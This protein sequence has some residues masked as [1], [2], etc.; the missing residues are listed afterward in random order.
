[1]RVGVTGAGG[2]CGGA[3]ARALDA[4]GHEVVTLGRSGRVRPG[5]E[6]RTW[7]AE[8]PDVPDLGGLDAVVHLAAAVGDPVT[9]AD[10][11]RCAVVNVD[12]AHRM[13]EAARGLRV[14][15]V[16]S[17]SVYDPRLDRSCVP[18]EHPTAGGHDNAYGRTK[19][20]GDAAARAA[21][22]VVLRPRAVY[23][24]G[25]PHLLPRLRRA[26]RGGTLTVP[27]DDVPLSLTHVDTLA[28]ACVH[29]LTAAPGAYNVAD[30]A[31]HRR[32]AVLTDVLTAD[33]RR[34]VRLRRVPVPLAGA[35]AA[36][37]TA[38]ARLR[39]VEPLLTR[40]AVDQLARPCVLDTGR[41][42][43]SGYDPPERMAPF[44]AALAVT[45]SVPA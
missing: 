14:V 4:A 28:E 41:L 2:F 19:A 25:D 10:A 22:A 15:W 20:L 24:P 43:A 37:A 17:A 12:A 39:G 38:T 8:L 11:R 9:R 6:H 1:M 31:P 35:A 18:E 7:D 13:L 27:G 26:V 40:Y 30:P 36:L 29:G 5:W 3:A 44:L 42:R 45:A 23:G 33:L 34:P 32:D 16:S 21:G